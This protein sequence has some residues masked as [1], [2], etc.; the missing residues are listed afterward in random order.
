[1][2]YRSKREIDAAQYNTENREVMVKLDRLFIDR[3]FIMTQR[4]TATLSKA[5]QALIA[6]ILNKAEAQA[7]FDRDVFTQLV[8]K[9][10]VNSRDNEIFILK[11]G[12]EVEV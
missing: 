2:P 11:D 8:D 10:R 5:F 1:M 12:T 6:D 4:S 3:D 7:E 9:I